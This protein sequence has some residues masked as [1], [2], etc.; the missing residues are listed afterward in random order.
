MKVWLPWQT[1]DDVITTPSGPGPLEALANGCPFI[2]PKYKQPR[3]RPN[4]VGL[5]SYR[6]RLVILNCFRN[7]LIESQLRE[8]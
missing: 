1:N 5:A 7:F 3:G 4:N 6:Q 2:Q 8:C